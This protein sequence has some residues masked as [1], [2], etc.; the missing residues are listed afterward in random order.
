[1]VG[2]SLGHQRLCGRAL[3]STIKKDPGELD[4]HDPLPNA[5]IHHEQRDSVVS[6]RLHSRLLLP[7]QT[8]NQIRNTTTIAGNDGQN[9]IT[10]QIN[11]NNG[12]NLII[13]RGS[14]RHLYLQLSPCRARRSS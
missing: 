5:P 11:L 13:S 4:R 1:M 6:I 7:T 14:V 10:D 8:F 9:A 3:P 2:A 12:Q